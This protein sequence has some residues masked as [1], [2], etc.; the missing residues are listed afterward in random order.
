MPVFFANYVLCKNTSWVPIFG[1]KLQLF[2]SR[3]KT[4]DSRLSIFFLPGGFGK[5]SYGPILTLKGEKVHY[6]L[7]SG[8]GRV[9]EEAELDAIAAAAVLDS[10]FDVD[11]WSKE[12]EEEEGLDEAEEDSW[13]KM[14]INWTIPLYN[15]FHI[16][17]HFLCREKEWH[18]YRANIFFFKKKILF[19]FVSIY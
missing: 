2:S 11:G 6:V 9:E 1:G 18:C 7:T 8:W 19:V 14:N 17:H 16:Q 5:A 4:Q 10:W 15:S 13:R 3:P 12:E